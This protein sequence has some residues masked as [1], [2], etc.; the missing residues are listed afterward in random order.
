[1][2]KWQSLG[3][4]DKVREI[5]STAQA[6]DPNHHLNPPFLSPYQIA[7][8]FD[9]RHP[10]ESQALNKEIGGKGTGEQT[11]LAQYLARQL[12]QICKDSPNGDIE[13]AFLWR[14]HLK[15]LQYQ[16][17]GKMIEASLGQSYDMSMFRI[18]PSQ[19]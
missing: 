8:E 12:S 19:G 1:M 16:Y 2:S 6:H 3:V 9:Q 18:R 10:E 17:D 13:G 11:S 14:E 4:A 5:L 15:T 7:I